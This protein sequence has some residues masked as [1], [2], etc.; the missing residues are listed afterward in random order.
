VILHLIKA[1][2]LL[3]FIYLPFSQAIFAQAS[4]LAGRD[5]NSEIPN[6]LGIQAN[7]NGED[8]M[9]GLSFLH[10]SV[11][12][13]DLRLTSSFWLRPY[14]KAV[15]VKQTE[16]IYFIY[17]EELYA[18]SLGLD[19]ELTLSRD[20]SLFS[21]AELGFALKIYRGSDRDKLDTVFPVFTAGLGCGFA[22]SAARNRNQFLLRLGY[23]Y[24]KLSIYPNRF[25]LAWIFV[26]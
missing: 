2:V 11:S 16:N 18:L 20:I 9:L 8:F 25:Y 3:A 23:Q 1:V 21:S 4:E 12:W 15:L 6:Y 10:R 22:Y 17:K 7:M 24:C 19:K 5:S 14:G 26:L 13:L